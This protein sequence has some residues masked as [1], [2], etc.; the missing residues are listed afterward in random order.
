MAVAIDT[1]GMRRS[2]WM[3]VV[4]A[5]DGATEISIVCPFDFKTLHLISVIISFNSTI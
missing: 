1:I 2:S 4:F 5:S 3:Y